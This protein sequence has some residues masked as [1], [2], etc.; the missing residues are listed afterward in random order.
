MAK[1]KLITIEAGDASGK[2]TQT[3]AL[4]QRL[5]AEGHRVLQVAYPNYQSD[6]SA[7]VK[8]YL[9]GAFGDKADA[10]SPYGASAFFAVDRYASYLQEWKDA[11]EAGAIILADRYTTSNMAHQAVKI[12]DADQ[13]EEFLSWLED[14]EFQRLGLPRPDKVIFLDMPPELSDKLLAARAA[15]TH[16]DI[17]EKDAAYLHRCYHAY[18]LVAEKYGWVRIPCSEKGKLRT[19]EAI[20]EDVYKAVADIM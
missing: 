18:Q 17:H 13:R 4:C 19:I 6:S 3:K 1:G 11:Y 14:F 10:V 5:Q 7:L 16:K 9:G 15:V 12:T 8:M 20:H 2:A